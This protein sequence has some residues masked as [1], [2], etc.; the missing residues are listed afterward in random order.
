MYLNTIKDKTGSRKQKTRVGRGPGSGKGKTC[1]RGM[2]GQKSRSGMSVNGFEGGQMP[3]Y[4]RL[5]KRGF[6]PLNPKKYSIINIGRLQKFIADGSIDSSKDIDFKALLSAGL[7]RGKSDGIRLLGSGELDS[8]ISIEVDYASSSAVAAVEKL[9]GKI[10]IKSLKG[11]VKN[12][13]TNKVESDK[14]KE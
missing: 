6:N 1:G 5:P 12:N 11:P 13:K 4:R 3:I 14:G 2:K 8:K 10:E 7:V 9:G